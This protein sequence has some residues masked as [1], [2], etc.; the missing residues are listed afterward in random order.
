M[1]NTQQQE[2]EIENKEWLKDLFNELGP[3]EEQK[4]SAMF[5]TFRDMLS[6]MTNTTSTNVSNLDPIIEE[7]DENSN[8][9]KT[10][11]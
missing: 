1:S 10:V 2:V 4:V 11:E 9:K 7:T 3:E 5:K 6:S 8:I